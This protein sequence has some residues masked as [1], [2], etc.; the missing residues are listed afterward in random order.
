MVAPFVSSSASSAAWNGFVCAAPC[1]AA[2][3]D[4]DRLAEARGRFAV[5]RF[6]FGFT[7][8]ATARV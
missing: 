5:L 1:G 2:E 4:A 8:A 7:P 6:V 3:L